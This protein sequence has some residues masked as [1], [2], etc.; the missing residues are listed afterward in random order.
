MRKHSPQPKSTVRRVTELERAEMEKR[1]E[2]VQ[3]A[4]DVKDD[5]DLTHA[6]VSLRW[7]RLLRGIHKKYRILSNE[8]IDIQTGAIIPKAAP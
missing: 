8:D 2:E 1:A 7:H 3:I 6:Q 4:K 5:A